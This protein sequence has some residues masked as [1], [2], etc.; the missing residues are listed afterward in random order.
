MDQQLIQLVKDLR[1]SIISLR[2]EKKFSES[3]I[4]GLHHGL[5]VADLD[6]KFRKS[7]SVA[8]AIFRPLT[9]TDRRTISSLIFLAKRPPISS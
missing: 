5:L 8:Q 6:G 9:A 7:N 1:G 2:E 4:Q 3:I